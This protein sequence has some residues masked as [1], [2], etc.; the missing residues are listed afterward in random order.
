M[1]A[2]FVPFS[3]VHLWTL[4]AGAVVIAIILLIGRRGGQSE[5]GAR[6]LLT[7]LCLS[8]FV[9]SQA[10]WLGVP[11]GPELD[12]SIPFHLCDLA[13]VAAGFALITGRHRLASL[14]YYW[15]LAATI[16]GLATPAIT[17]GFPHPAFFAFFF[18]HFAVVAAALYLPIVRGWRPRGPWWHDPLTAWFWS[19]GYAVV[20][21]L[22]NWTLGTN[23]GF[24]AH[25]PVNPSLLDAMGPWPFYILG[26]ALLAL[27]FFVL[28]TIPFVKRC[29]C[30]KSSSPA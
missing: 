29:G 21:G 18:H 12:S 2:P 20:A 3:A 4:I 7:F 8:E 11:R 17:I 24:L 22:V 14:T 23:F 1:P 30:G 6:A 19:L 5:R 9:Y 27:L 13:A 10:A 25:K 28:L 15:G 16:Q 26:Q